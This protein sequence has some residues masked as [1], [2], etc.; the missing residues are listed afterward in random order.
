MDLVRVEKVNEVYIKVSAEPSL[1]MELSE[2]FT[3]EVPGA[4]FMPAVRNRVWDGKVRLFNA[5]TGLIYAGLLTHIVK[6]CKQRDYD[7][8]FSTV[9]LSL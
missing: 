5:M 6:F 2:H 9:P 8:E 4:K 7:I 3:F 1:K